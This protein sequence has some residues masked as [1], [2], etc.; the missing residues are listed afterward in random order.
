VLGNAQLTLELNHFVHTQVGTQQG[1][2]SGK[3][4]RDRADY[5]ARGFAVLRLGAEGA[6]YGSYVFGGYVGTR[7]LL[8][9]GSV[10][11]GLVGVEVPLWEHHLKF[12]GDWVIGTNAE[13]VAALGLEWS[14][15]SHERWELA[16]A[17]QLPSP[18]SDND[19]GF[20]VQISHIPIESSEAK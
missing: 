3:G 9:P 18:K 14:V 4:G 8:G 2:A 5:A 13:S 20:I 19:Y 11:G 17:A 16:M 7:S 1:I 10:G 6:R 15:D 12:A